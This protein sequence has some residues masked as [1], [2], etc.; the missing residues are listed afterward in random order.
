[1][2]NLRTLTWICCDSDGHAVIVVDNHMTVIVMYI[3]VTVSDRSVIVVDMIAIVV[4][5]SEHDCDS[6]GHDYHSCRLVVDMTVI[7]VDNYNRGV[8]QQVLLG[9]TTCRRY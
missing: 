7:V 8:F 2:E 4:D 1:M 6:C 3:I 9:K 5:S